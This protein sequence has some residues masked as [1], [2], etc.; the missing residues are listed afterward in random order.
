MLKKSS[1]LT[2]ETLVGA[3]PPVVPLVE[4][5]VGAVVVVNRIAHVHVAGV[6]VAELAVVALGPE[7]GGERPEVE[8][9]ADEVPGVGALA[10][11]LRQG[12][13]GRVAAHEG[14]AHPGALAHLP[15]VLLLVAARDEGRTADYGT[16]SNAATDTAAAAAGSTRSERPRVVD[17]TLADVAAPDDAALVVAAAAAAAGA[18][19]GWSGRG[20]PARAVGHATRVHCRPIAVVLAAVARVPAGGM[21]RSHCCLLEGACI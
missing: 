7:E 19:A 4:V 18:A 16:A 13:G 14:L 15:E 17:A 5:V 21:V 6:A 9:P 2:V 10:L 3:L 20:R 8:G 11:A 12:R 1:I